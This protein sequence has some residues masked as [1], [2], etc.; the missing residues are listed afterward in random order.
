MGGGDEKQRGEMAEG[1]GSD[2]KE[3]ARARAHARSR[4][5]RFTWILGARG[6][7]AI[8]TNR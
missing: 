5:M 4:N 7:D 6:G 3:R 1:E 8:G 2:G